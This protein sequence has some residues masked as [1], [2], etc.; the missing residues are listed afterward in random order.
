MAEAMA[1]STP[2]QSERIA[3]GQAPSQFGELW[4]PAGS[5]P[6]PVAKDYRALHSTTPDSLM[7]VNESRMNTVGYQLVGCHVRMQIPV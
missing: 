1:R 6:A 2:A 3:Y 5:G 4:L 7:P